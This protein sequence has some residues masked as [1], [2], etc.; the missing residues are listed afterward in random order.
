MT[1][2]GALLGVA[3]G[4]SNALGYLLVV[5]LSRTLG[6]EDFGGYTALTT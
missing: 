6:P 1:M 2:L 4:L 5:L 3:M